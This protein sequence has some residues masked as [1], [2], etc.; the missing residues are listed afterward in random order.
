[1]FCVSFIYDDF[2]RISE[3]TQ[4][5][6][7]IQAAHSNKFDGEGTV[8]I[9][10]FMISFCLSFTLLSSKLYIEFGVCFLVAILS[11]ILLMIVENKA[12]N[13][14]LP[15]FIFKRPINLFLYFNG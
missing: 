1:M 10:L 3:E 9:T 7:E 8:L 11:L 4:N 5:L 14:I 15:P 13:P 2:K 12:D 6:N